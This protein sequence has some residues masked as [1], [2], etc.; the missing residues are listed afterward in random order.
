MV[1]GE[2]SEGALG[3]GD[4]L[5][6]NAPARVGTQTDWTKV[7]ASN[8]FTCGIRVAHTLWCWGDNYYGELGV[9]D[10]T[11]RYSPVQVVGDF[12]ADVTGSSGGGHT[13]ARSLD[14]GLFCWGAGNHGQ[15]GYGG[16]SEQLSPLRVGTRTDWNQ[17]TAGGAHTCAIRTNHLLL[18]WGWNRRGQLGL[19]NTKSNLVPRIV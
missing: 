4:R 15:L 7:T 19:G 5:D 1:L 12:W 9:G 13:C 6:R 17:P 11:D 10:R 3:L 8:G 14:G 18:C 16:K 2:G